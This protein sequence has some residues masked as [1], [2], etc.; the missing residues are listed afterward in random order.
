MNLTRRSPQPHF[1]VLYPTVFCRIVKSFLQYSEKAKGNV[2][3]QGAWQIVGLKV[4]LH[5]LLLA[6]FPAEA[7]HGRSN[8]Q[9]LQFCR[10]Q[11]VRQGL[12]I[13]GYLR[14]LLLEFAH[15]TADFGQNERVCLELL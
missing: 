12:N 13:G 1:E 14:S 8:A 2:W 7:S 9:I 10:M 3:R 5:L 11:L 4:N 6:E 15:T